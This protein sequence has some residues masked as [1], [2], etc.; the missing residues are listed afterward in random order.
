MALEQKLLEVEQH[1]QEVSTALLAAD[2]PRLE[3]CSTTLRDAALTFARAMAQV[4]DPTALPAA[5]RRRIQAIGSLL[6]I[7]RE[8][9]LRLSAATSRQAAALLGAAGAESTYE[10]AL[11]SRASAS[12]PRRV[13]AAG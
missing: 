9:L 1:L 12:V 11:G 3:Q 2:A 6:A 5:L 7:Q 8:N 10:S 13:R 4:P